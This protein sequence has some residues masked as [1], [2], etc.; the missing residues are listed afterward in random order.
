M[1]M[2]KRSNQRLAS[3]IAT[4][5]TSAT[6]P[7]PPTRHVAREEHRRAPRRQC[8][9]IGHLL[10]AGDGDIACVIRDLSTAGARV[11]VHGELALPSFV[12]LRMDGNGAS[13]ECRVAWQR[14]QEAGLAF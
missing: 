14:G 5:K 11:H 8:Y 2:D 1:V 13:Q 4:L 9:R 10:S 6:T 12:V 3:R 7:L